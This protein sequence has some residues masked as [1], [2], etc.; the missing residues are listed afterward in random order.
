M[1]GRLHEHSTGAD[2]GVCERTAQEQVRGR[3]HTREQCALHQH[4][5]E[6][7]IVR[8]QCGVVV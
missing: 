1:F 8:S 3:L 2:R 6:T 5:E 7:D 4:T